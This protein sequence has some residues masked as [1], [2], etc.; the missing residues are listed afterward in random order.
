MWSKP[1]TSRSIYFDK[2]SRDRVLEVGDQ[3]L[4][5][6]PSSTYKLQAQWQGP[7]PITRKI[8]AVDYEVQLDGKLKKV[9]HVN[10]LRKFN[11]R[12]EQTAC[13][14][15]VE[16]PNLSQQESVEDVTFGPDLDA[17]QRKQLKLLLLSYSHVFTD[18]PG[19]TDL[20]THS[21]DT[22]DSAPVYSKPYRLLESMKAAV[23]KE[24]QK[25][26]ELGW[27]QPSISPYTTVTIVMYLVIKSN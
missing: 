27:I 21:V 10:L 12:S 5:L 3:V 11:V 6:L 24:T 2:G 14:G 7:F 22:G 19:K 13:F 18:E 26:L 1:R 9:Y 15:D 23:T 16:V 4:I 8:S 25:L 20:V 17:D